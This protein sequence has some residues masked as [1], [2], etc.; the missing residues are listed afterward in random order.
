MPGG[1]RAADEP[2]TPPAQGVTSRTPQ[3]PGKERARA[4]AR[5]AA[6]RNPWNAGQP[7]AAGVPAPR[8]L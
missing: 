7:A 6:G 4:E 3:T 8:P 1:R 2:S 5:R